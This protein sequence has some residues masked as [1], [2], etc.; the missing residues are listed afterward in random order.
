MPLSTRRPPEGSR[1]ATLDGVRA[2]SILLVVAGHTL[3]LG[4]K[5]LELNEAATTMGMALFFCL[6]GFLITRMLY[7]SP[8]IHA[9]LVKRVLRIVPAVALYL[10]LLVVFLGLPLKSLVL[11]LLFVSNYVHSGLAGGPVG[12]LWSLCVEMQFY[13]AISLCVG[14]LG[15]RGVWL[16]PLAAPIVTGL[17]I[18]AGA[19][20]N[21]MTHLRVDEIL[22]GGCLALAHVHRGAAITRSLS[23]SRVAWL[24]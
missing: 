14:L 24:R 8:D 16:I 2:A 7:R 9:F 18:E 23:D 3:P 19:T 17:R 11:N 21:I 1:I 12:H 20:V 4:P 13:V 15:S 6:S 22:A 5:S 10:V